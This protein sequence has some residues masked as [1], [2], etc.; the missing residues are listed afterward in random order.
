MT[1]PLAAR[2]DPAIYRVP[3]T[4]DTAAWLG[5]AGFIDV[6]IKRSADHPATVWFTATAT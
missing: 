4:L 1:K 2:F 6:G 3:P 5:A